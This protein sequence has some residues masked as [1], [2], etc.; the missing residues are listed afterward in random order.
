MLE[1]KELEVYYG[2]RRVLDD[3]HLRAYRGE[4]H[5][6]FGLNGSGKTTLLRTLY[7]FKRLARGK[8]E[9]NGK[10]LNQEDI[11][12]LES[13]QYF[14]PKMK[15]IEYLRVLRK[16]ESKI[17]A[18]NE[19]FELPL[20]EFVGKYSLGM[21]KKLAYMG[22]LLQEKPILI[23]DEPFK[24]VN[25]E[26]KRKMVQILDQIKQDK[27]IVMASHHLDNLIRVCDRISVLEHG[28]L[29]ETWLR[30]NFQML[31]EKYGRL[32]PTSA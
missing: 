19:L 7:G 6:L 24:G 20:D 12:F 5:G 14:Y 32:A 25:P 18:L 2:K 28:L 26:G 29:T 1:I 11:A 23:I 9:Y 27:V 22:T 3:I 8:F 21:K 30:E 15:G 4:V 31:E 17:R 10:V 16:P 13:D